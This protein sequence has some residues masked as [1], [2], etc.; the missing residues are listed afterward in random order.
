MADTARQAACRVLARCRKNAAWSEEAIRA[1]ISRSGLNEND[2]ALCSKISIG[3]LQNSSLLDYYINCYSNTPTGKLNPKVLDILRLS[4]YQI[5]FLDKIPVFAAVN[6]GVKLCKAGENSKAAGLVNAVLR[7][8]AEQRTELPEVPG[9]GTAQYLSTVYSHPLWLAEMCIREHG[10]DF[11]EHFLA[12]NNEQAPI[13]AHINPL[14]RERDLCSELSGFGAE[15]TEFPSCIRLR[16]TAGITET[17]AFRDGAFYIQDLAAHL[18]AVAGNPQPGM[19]VLDACAAP[20]GKSVACAMRM[21]NRGRIISCDIHEKKLRMIEENAQRLGISIIDTLP[22]DARKPYEG[23]K[24]IADLV[25]ADVPCSGLGVIRRKPE[26]RW[27]PQAEINRLPEIQ[28]DILEGLFPCV[29]A[30]GVLVY[31][32]CTIRREENGDVIDAFLSRHPDF[33]LEA[34]VLP[35]LGSVPEGRIT[36]WPHIHDTDG[37]FICKLRKQ[38][39]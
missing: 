13:F 25:I 30:G 37:F 23:M 10:Y 6:E 34:F 33:S 8:I 3:V 5:L 19:T 27:K 28:S 21:G 7:R 32:T 38:Y 16:T 18:A 4:A 1:E 15:A 24:D 20:G 35:V 14:R 36:L 39:D 12:A 2:A 31:S 9:K 11:T 26:I 29:K 22:M 17:A